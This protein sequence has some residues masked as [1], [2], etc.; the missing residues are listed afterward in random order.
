VQVAPTEQ[1]TPHEPQL[2]ESVSKSSWRQLP[3][4]APRPPS[5]CWQRVPIWEAAQL[6][7]TAVQLP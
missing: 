7:T 3:Q 1:I 5:F 4:Q 2:F 6:D